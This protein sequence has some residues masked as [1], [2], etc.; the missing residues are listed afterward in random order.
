MEPHNLICIDANYLGQETG[1][2]ANR[3][4]A[5][6]VAQFFGEEVVPVALGP[7]VIEPRAAPELHVEEPS[8]GEVPGR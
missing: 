8:R 7:A 5:N 4:H 3:L 6:L 1:V 2:P